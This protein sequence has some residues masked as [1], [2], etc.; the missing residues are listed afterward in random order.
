MSEALRLADAID[1][2]T[3]KSLDNLTCASAAT[4]LRR[5]HALNAELVEALRSLVTATEGVSINDYNE[6]AHDIAVSRARAALTKAG[7]S[8]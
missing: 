1:P 2:L 6:E 3:R 5:L 8:K 7:E 4:E